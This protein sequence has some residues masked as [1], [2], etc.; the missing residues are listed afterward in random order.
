MGGG[1]FFLI[2]EV[3]NRNTSINPKNLMGIGLLLHHIIISNCSTFALIAK[4][5]V[6]FCRAL[7]P[8]VVLRN[9]FQSYLYYLSDFTLVRFVV[10]QCYDITIHFVFKPSAMRLW[11]SFSIV[12]MHQILAAWINPPW[13]WVNGS[14]L[15]ACNVFMNIFLHYIHVDI[16][17]NIAFL[18]GVPIL[19]ITCRSL[20]RYW[21][22]LCLQNRSTSPGE[23]ARLPF[24]LD[25]DNAHSDFCTL[26]KGST[27]IVLPHWVRNNW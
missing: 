24:D 25:G 4:N 22:L 12:V 9:L 10:S 19:H 15:I 27:Y 18:L 8:W 23:Q 21:A 5:R 26:H 11:C 20:M 13:Q 16:I 14:T 17:A 3:C 6:F 2:I 1:L 7:D